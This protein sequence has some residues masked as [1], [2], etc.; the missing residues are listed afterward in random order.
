MLSTIFY[1]TSVTYYNGRNNI[2][3][4]SELDAIKYVRD[5]LSQNESV[6]PEWGYSISRIGD[7]YEGKRTF[8]DVNKDSIPDRVTFARVSS[9]EF[10]YRMQI[11]LGKGDGSFGDKEEIVRVYE[12]RKRIDEGHL[13]APR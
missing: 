12:Q 8:M 1:L 10:D 5:N 13:K 7:V 2:I 3:S 4:D 6:L 9:S 11:E